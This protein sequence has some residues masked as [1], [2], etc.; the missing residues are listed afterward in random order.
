MSFCCQQMTSQKNLLCF[1]IIVG[2]RGVKSDLFVVSPSTHTYG[3][4]ATFETEGNERGVKIIPTFLRWQ[5]R[6]WVSEKYHFWKTLRWWLLSRIGNSSSKCGIKRG[7]L[8]IHSCRRFNYHTRTI[9]TLNIKSYL[10]RSPC[11]PRSILALLKCS[12]GLDRV[13]RNSKTF[14]FF[15]AHWF[16]PLDFK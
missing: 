1:Q 10:D 7:R 4:A 9:F 3:I 8:M 5:A 6:K 15:D 16:L 11:L 13:A 2:C 12:I 14:R